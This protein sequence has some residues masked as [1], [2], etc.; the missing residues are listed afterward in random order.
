M[1]NNTLEI[2]D[3]EMGMI[4]EKFQ[5]GELWIRGNQVGFGYVDGETR[6]FLFNDNMRY[7]TYRTGDV[8]M[9]DENNDIVILG[10]TDR[11]VK[12]HGNRVELDEISLILKNIKNI[13]DAEVE[14]LTIDDKELLVAFVVANENEVNIH[15][16]N[17]FL[18]ERLPKYMLV[19]KYIFVKKIPITQH[20]KVDHATLIDCLEDSVQ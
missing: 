14:L 20:G 7:R 13:S 17:A 11:Q 2:R 16:W 1:P 6:G 15:E 3:F 19:Q 8:A 4:T 12:I 10:R 9:Y 18:I 5:L